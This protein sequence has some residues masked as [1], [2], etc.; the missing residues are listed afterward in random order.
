MKRALFL[1]DVH[2]PFHDSRALDLALQ[3]GEDVDEV[4][5]LGDFADMYGV[6]SHGRSPDIVETIEDEIFAVKKVLKH[7]Q[8][9]I[10][11][12]K[13]VFIE[14]NHC[15]RLKRY[16]ANHA[17]ELHT[18][19]SIAGL[20]DLESMGYEFVPYGPYQKYNVLGMED[21]IARHE[22]LSGG[23]HVAHNT[24]VKAGTSV[25][26]GHVHRQQISN[27]VLMDGKLATGISVPTLCDIKH[28]VMSYVK[29]F[30]QW[31]QG[32]AIVTQVDGEWF[33]DNLV[34]KDYKCIFDGHLFKA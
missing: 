6:S 30:H 20:F 25:I 28:P 10:P 1:S 4:I 16:I 8:N 22:P 7:I 33:V 32:S 31:Q 5:L 19:I 21:L 15:H 26:F 27:V 34:F 24:A 23:V 9:A 17:P 18:F 2:V 29:N 3:I 14:G 12:A 13:R 11:N